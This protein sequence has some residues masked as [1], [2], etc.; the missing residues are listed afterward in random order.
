MQ[1][2][3]K[4]IFIQTGNADTLNVSPTNYT[5]L[6]QNAGELGLVFQQNGNTY[7]EVMLDSGATSATPTG[8]VAA[9]QAAYWKDRSRYLVTNDYR[10]AVG[11]QTTSGF[12]NNVAGVF[13]TAVTANATVLGYGQVCCILQQGNNI[14]LSTPTSLTSAN[15]GDY[16][17]ANQST[18]RANFTNAAANTAPP[19]EALGIWRGASATSVANADVNIPSAP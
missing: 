3:S 16:V 11:G 1:Q 6:G 9:N 2:P 18:V 17:V 13:R 7:Q 15:F 14:P 10:F 19:T 8:V 4:T 5:S 12:A